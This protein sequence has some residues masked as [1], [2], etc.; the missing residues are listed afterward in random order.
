MTNAI[1]TITSATEDRQITRWHAFGATDA[2]HYDIVVTRESAS[3]FRVRWSVK[4]PKPIALCPVKGASGGGS[5]RAFG[6][7]EK[8]EAEALAFAAAKL[9]ACRKAAAQ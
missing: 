5:W 7:N 8:T 3:R 2:L 9:E 6:R 4:R 1:E